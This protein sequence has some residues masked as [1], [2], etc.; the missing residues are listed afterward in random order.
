MRMEECAIGLAHI[1]IPTD[2]ITESV[3][4]YSELGFEVAYTGINPEDGLKAVFLRL[5]DMT[6]EVYESKDPKK[7]WGAIEHIAINVKDIEAAYDLICKRALNTLDDEI[8]FLPYWDNG[9]KYF[10]IEGPN[11]EKVEFSQYL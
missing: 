8:H 7:C 2:D 4:F 1:G 3:L 11:K 6:L 5:G 9:V 10:T